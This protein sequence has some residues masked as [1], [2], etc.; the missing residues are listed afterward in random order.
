VTDW[1]NQ[2]QLG[3]DS[4]LKEFPSIE[5]FVE[6]MDSKRNTSK[7]YLDLFEK[8]LDTK[9]NSVLFDLIITTDNNALD[10]LLSHRDNLFNSCPIVFCGVNAFF[11]SLLLGQKN[12]TGVV[13][14]VDFDN[15]IEIAL[16][17]RPDCDTVFLI[18][19]NT[20]TGLI[21][22]NDALNALSSKIF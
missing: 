19:D 13:E 22:K 6:Y 17:A 16:K 10:F 18:C 15:T 20:E 1:T 21:N 11:P 5:L 12:I 3:I 4:G 9:Y 14:N 7:Q 2:E 8:V